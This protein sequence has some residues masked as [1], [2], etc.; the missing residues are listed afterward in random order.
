M[1]TDFI[2][3][4]FLDREDAPAIIKRYLKVHPEVLEL[5]L[6]ENVELEQ[7]EKWL[8][9]ATQRAKKQPT[10]VTR[11]TSL[12]RW[13][14]KHNSSLFPAAANGLF[15]WYVVYRIRIRFSM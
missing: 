11:K 9:R 8:I 15:H 7:L 2:E 4:K 10:A 12:S 1:D 14:V 3:A 6:M 5:Y 13:K